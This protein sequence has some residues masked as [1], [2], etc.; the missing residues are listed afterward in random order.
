M[1]PPRLIYKPGRLKILDQRL[2]P[3]KIA[4]T[5]ARDAAETAAA[6]KDMV[7]R[8]AP[9]IGCAAAYGMVL[10]LEQQGSG[11][12]GQWSVVGGRK[13]DSATAARK[14]LV[15]AGITLKAARPTAVA[16]FYAVD[17]MLEKAD[18]WLKAHPFD[19]MRFLAALRREAGLI[20]REDKAACARMGDFGAGLLK[21]NSIVL[22]HC[23]AGAL[24]TMGIG[25]AV[26]VITKA[27]SLKKIKHAYSSETRPYLQ[28]A[29]LTIWELAR[30]GV[31]SSLITDNMAAHI[32]KTCGV[33][34]V[35]VGADRIAA[36]GDTANKIGT[37]GL[38]VL[39]RYHGIPFYVAAPAPTIDLKLKNGS[40][41]KI[42]ER[43][44]D[45]VTFINGRL[46]AP[47]GVNARHP[48]FDVTPAGLITALV[49]EKGVISPVNK[50][51]I[52][53]QLSK[54]IAK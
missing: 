45:E 42:E 48:A 16:L 20:T 10:E 18:L 7:L 17:R 31:P 24:A 23:N 8:G 43:S 53:K 44:S 47:K 30:S 2:L 4:Y 33:N 49:T 40:L 54:R 41:I 5:T 1:I 6:I 9:L 12:S 50:K 28:G 3:H 36:N 21:K 32:M 37:Y 46:C 22:T 13:L 39:A 38:A 11:A 52:V 25:T 34:A 35:I 27:H 29:R 14:T 19:Y 15:A 51:N 26:G